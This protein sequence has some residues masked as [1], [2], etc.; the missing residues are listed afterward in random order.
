VSLGGVN[1]T[2]HVLEWAVTGG[3]ALREAAA[4]DSAAAIADC[5]D[6]RGLD[7]GVVDAIFNLLKVCVK[8]SADDFKIG[9]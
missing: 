3:C 6:D 5:A 4:N 8:I 2:S 9:S 7:G 1:I